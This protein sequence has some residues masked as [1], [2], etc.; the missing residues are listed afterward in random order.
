MS[1]FDQNCCVHVSAASYRNGVFGG[2]VPIIGLS[3]IRARRAIILLGLGIPWP[4]R[5]FVLWWDI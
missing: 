3:S 4:L 1:C 2:L 5:A